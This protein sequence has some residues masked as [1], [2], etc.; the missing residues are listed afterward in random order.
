MEVGMQLNSVLLEGLPGYKVDGEEGLEVF[1][2]FHESVHEGRRT[3]APVEYSAVECSVLVGVVPSYYTT[4][5]DKLRTGTRVR[6][7]GYYYHLSAGGYPLFV[8]DYVEFLPKASSTKE[9]V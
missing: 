7:I 5:A 2:L 9:P 4:I 1:R 8:A 3:E 6:I